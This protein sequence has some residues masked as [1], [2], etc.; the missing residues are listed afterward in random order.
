MSS[1]EIQG[2]KES[3]MDMLWHEAKLER[4]CFQT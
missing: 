1:L 4:H 3:M 2:E